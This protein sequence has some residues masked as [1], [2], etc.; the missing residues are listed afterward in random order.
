MARS[1]SW[2][3]SLGKEPFVVRVKNGK[4]MGHVQLQTMPRYA[5]PEFLDALRQ[6]TPVPMVVDAECGMPLDLSQWD[7][8]WE[9][10][11]NDAALNPDP[12]N[13][14]LLDDK[15]R[16]LLWEPPGGPN[17]AAEAVVPTNVTWL[18]KKESIAR[19]SAMSAQKPVKKRVAPSEVVDVSRDAQLRNIDAS[20]AA[21][22][23]D[24][25]L[26][27]VKHP[28]KRGVHAVESYEFL[29]DPV[30]WANQ[31][32]LFRFMERPG[33]RPP[34]DEDPRLNCA[35]LRPMKSD[36]DTFL[37]YYLTETDDAALSLID[38]RMSVP[39]YEVPANSY[40]KFD[41]VRD[42]ETTKV[43]QDINN[44]FILNVD[45]G[46]D[47]EDTK[48]GQRSRGKG[49]YY[50]N[51]ERK[52][53]LNKRRANPSDIVDERWDVIHLTHAELV[54]NELRERD[55]ALLDVMDPHYYLMPRDGEGE[56]D[57]DLDVA[58]GGMA[59]GS[60]QPTNGHAVDEDIHMNGGSSHYANGGEAPSPPKE[61]E[62]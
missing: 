17:R 51:I 62:T 42:Y 54:G 15:D 39:P 24:F 34:E 7:G 12:L 5:K 52:M 4:L 26:E 38:A 31:Y 29:P 37:S 41:F 46:D 48:P 11:G 16:E 58:M 28:T 9:P 20:F 2:Y 8:L 49:A 55:E 59:A 53:T 27:D 44:E 13:L 30:L 36:Y 3:T 10:E 14:P 61:E 18:R 23:E 1:A 19:Q 32:D 21:A 56:A 45:D 6:R 35:V 47:F 33:N 50:K 40:T 43:E 60:G 25:V 22:N 57:E